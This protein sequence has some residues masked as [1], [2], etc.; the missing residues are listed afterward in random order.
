MDKI[1]ELILEA[2]KD[3]KLTTYQIAKKTGLNW[4]TTMNH[5]LQM[6]ADGSLNHKIEKTR[7]GRTKH[8]W[9]KKI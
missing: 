8:W 2:L 6:E 1:N 5:C 3:G 9:F 7:W 4:S